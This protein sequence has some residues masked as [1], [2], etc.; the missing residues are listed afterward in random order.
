[1]VAHSK[2]HTLFLAPTK[3][4]L[5]VLCAGWLVPDLV[6][7]AHDRIPDVQGGSKS[8][9]AAALQLAAKLALEE[10]AARGRA[11]ASGGCIVDGQWW[12]GAD[13]LVSLATDGPVGPLQRV[14]A[15]E[16][17]AVPV[18]ANCNG[19]EQPCEWTWAAGTASTDAGASGAAATITLMRSDG[20]QM[21]GS[22]THNCSHI[23][24]QSPAGAGQW[25]NLNHGI[26]RV[27][28]VSMTHFDVGYTENSAEHLLDDFSQTWF[29]EAFNVSRTLRARGGPERF[30]WTSHP[31]LLWSYINNETGHVTEAQLADL[32]VAILAGDVIWHAN[33]MNLQFESAEPSHMAEQLELTQRLRQR[34][35]LLSD[36]VSRCHWIGFVPFDDLIVPWSNSDFYL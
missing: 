32:D 19:G 28:I 22:V 35:V 18:E 21:E 6:V 2:M 24:W 14:G 17:D 27:H 20:V 1:M 16:N 33:P 36:I 31:W 34:Y 29:P 30:V 13:L 4:S 8:L 10:S 12:D 5:L 7:Q 25:Q 23:S 9:Q 15:F 11:T 3:A 26:E